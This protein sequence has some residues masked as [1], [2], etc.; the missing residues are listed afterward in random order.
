MLLD[1]EE[2]LVISIIY[3]ATQRIDERTAA[4]ALTGERS[5][6]MINQL[7]LN[8]NGTVYNRFEQTTY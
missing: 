8:M 7:A 2:R 3:S 5:E 6:K 4:M 1:T